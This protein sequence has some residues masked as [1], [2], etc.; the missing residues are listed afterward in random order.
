MLMGWFTRE[1]FLI[2]CSGSYIK[3]RNLRTNMINLYL[4]F[5]KVFSFSFSLL[6]FGS[7]ETKEINATSTLLTQQSPF[8]QTWSPIDSSC[9]WEVGIGL[10]F[11]IFFN[12]FASA[13]RWATI[14]PRNRRTRV[15][16]FGACNLST[17]IRRF[18]KL[19]SVTKP[20]PYIYIQ[21]LAFPLLYANPRTSWIH[22]LHMFIYN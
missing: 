4:S 17:F 3:S 12:S 16:G 10:I 18:S 20:S 8:H 1:L 7:K 5:W 11:R 6:S 9:F 19:L 15:I 14:R 2:S 21:W 22:G 13:C